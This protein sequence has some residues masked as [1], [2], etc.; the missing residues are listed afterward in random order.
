MISLARLMVVGPSEL[1]RLVIDGVVRNRNR[2]PLHEAL[3]QLHGGASQS[4]RNRTGSVS[5][6]RA[7]ALRSRSTSGA[8]SSPAT[9]AFRRARI[10]STAARHTRASP[11]AALSSRPC[12]VIDGPPFTGNV[13][14]R[15]VVALVVRTVGLEPGGQEAR[16]LW[17]APRKGLRPVDHYFAWPGRPSQGVPSADFVEC[18]LPV[19]GNIIVGIAQRQSGT[20]RVGMHRLALNVDCRAVPHPRRRAR[21]A[22]S[23]PVTMSRSR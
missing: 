12:D 16:C 18:R 4:R 1:D 20:G 14:L 11:R 2:G 9:P 7:T 8:N 15:A 10:S 17:V 5:S 3:G 19:L 23:R 22:C 21:T 6:S 13:R